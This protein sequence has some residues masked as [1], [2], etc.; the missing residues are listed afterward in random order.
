M[1][2]MSLHN[3]IVYAQCFFS[4]KNDSE[5]TAAS[6]RYNFFPRLSLPNVVKKYPFC[7]NKI[8]TTFKNSSGETNHCNAEH[9]TIKSCPFGKEGDS[10]SPARKIARPF[11]Q[12]IGE[13]STHL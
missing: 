4:S 3:L 7:F 6:N 13:T 2:P 1:F 11:P 12:Q 5:E 10:A 8:I 9:D